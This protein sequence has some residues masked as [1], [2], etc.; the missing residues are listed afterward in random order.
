[1]PV[2][3]ENNGITYFRFAMILHLSSGTNYGHYVTV[4]F[5]GEKYYLYDDSINTKINR[6]IFEYTQKN[7]D[8]INKNTVMYFYYKK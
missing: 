3:I 8:I 5:D 1:M 4:M 7:V 2:Y 6:N